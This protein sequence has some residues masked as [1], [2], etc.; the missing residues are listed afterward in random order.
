MTS[1]TTTQP[2]RPTPAPS[3]APNVYTS[4]RRTIASELVKLR[5]LRSSVWLLVVATAFTVVLGPV[6]SLGQVLSGADRDVDS[7]AVVSLSTWPSSSIR[8]RCSPS[9]SSTAPTWAPEAWTRVARWAVF[10]AAPPSGRRS[11]ADQRALRT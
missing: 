9:G 7:S 4:L 6:Q 10:L 5:T 3:A 2:S 1:D 8:V 11:Q